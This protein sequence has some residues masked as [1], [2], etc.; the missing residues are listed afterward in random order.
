MTKTIAKH[1]RRAKAVFERAVF[2]K[3]YALVN[4]FI[5]K[6]CDPKYAMQDLQRFKF[7]K[8]YDY[9]QGEYCV[10][11]HSNWWYKLQLEEGV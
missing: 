10:H 1:T 9:G 5:G 2:C 6:D 8:L 7:A 11:V 3:C 4:D